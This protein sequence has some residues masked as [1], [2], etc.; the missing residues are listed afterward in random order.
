MNIYVQYIAHSFSLIWV[1]FQQQSSTEGNWVKSL[2]D[3]S[4]MDVHVCKL[5][6]IISKLFHLNQSV[7]NKK[8]LIPLT[9]SNLFSKELPVFLA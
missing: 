8:L 1:D 7:C 3:A 5:I 6:S 4:Y 2:I 9:V